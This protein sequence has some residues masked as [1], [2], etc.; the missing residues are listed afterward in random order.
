MKVF[1]KLSLAALCVGLSGLLHAQSTTYNWSGIGAANSGGS[2][3]KNQG[4]NFQVS[5]NLTNVSSSSEMYVNST[6]T[7]VQTVYFRANGGSTK[8]FSLQNIKVHNASSDN[9]PL[10]TFTITVSD[11]YGNQ[12]AQHSL[13]LNQNMNDPVPALTG[14]NFTPAWPANGYPYAALVR[15][16]FRYVSGNRPASHLRFTNW[17]LGSVSSVQ[18]PFVRTGA[19]DASSYCAGSAVSVAFSGGVNFG[20]GNSYSL[21]LSDANGSFANPVSIG[22]LASN[23]AS[24]SINGTIPAGTAEGSGYRLRVTGS[25]PSYTSLG[26]NGSN[27]TIHAMASVNAVSNQMVCNGNATAA[28]DFSGTAATGYTWTNDNS[29]IGIGA[30][31]TGNI[32]SF[33]AQNSSNSVQTANLIVT[34]VNSGCNGLTTSFSIAVNASPNATIAYATPIAE[35]LGTAQVTQNGT[36]GGSYSS[37]AGLSINAQTGAI[38]LAASTPGTYTVTYTVAASGGCAEYQTATQVTLLP[39]NATIAYGGSP[40]CSG[41]GTGTATRTGTPGGTF[42]ASAGLVIDAQ[43]GAIDVA[44]SASGN[45]PVQYSVGTDVAQTMVSIRPATLINSSSNQVL[46]AGAQTNEVA[47]TGA[48]GLTFSWTNTNTA[49]G[50]AASGSDLVP[51]FTAT[52]NTATSTLATVTVTAA[53]GTGC[54]LRKVMIYRYTVKPIPSV[55]AVSNQTL[56]AGTSTAAATLS[57]PVAGTAYGWTNNNTTIGL[58]AIGTGDIASF[59]AQN[60]TGAIQTATVTVTPQAAGCVGQPLSFTYTVSPSA[61]SISYAGSPFCQGGTTSPVRAGSGGGIFSASPAGLVI[62][63][64][65]GTVNLAQSSPGQYTV[66]YTVAAGA[67]CQPTATAQLTIKPTATVDAVANQVYCTGASTS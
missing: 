41:T 61:G 59:G 62:D 20:A 40:F 42:S 53:G 36:T 38:D 16:D 33:A 21:Q 37:T 13:N 18:P 14:F 44:A 2:G 3:F 22:A 66:S 7:A 25:A 52:N 57:G 27:I 47:L 17:T 28:I 65:T 39:F 15:I 35:R 10:S 43:T 58:G 48:P 51:A 50:L 29:S 12:I 63:A 54:D 45:Y 31:G 11:A 32:A 9:F 6:S 64:A 5:N 30:A 4:S 49:I 24:G 60:N 19:A 56:C 55:D 67:P 8:S 26:D 1:R 46:C 23:A 34:A